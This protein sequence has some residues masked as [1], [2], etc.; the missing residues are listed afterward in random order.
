MSHQCHCLVLKLE[1][2]GRGFSKLWEV[3]KVFKRALTMSNN[4]LTVNGFILNYTLKK[5]K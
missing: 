5:S 2:S 1:Y 4:N 3:I